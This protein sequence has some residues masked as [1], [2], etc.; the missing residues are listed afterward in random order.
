MTTTATAGNAGVVEKVVEKSPVIDK[1][2]TE[3]AE[4]EKTPTAER[5]AAAPD[6]RRALGRGLES[7]LPSGPRVVTSGASAVAPGLRTGAVTSLSPVNPGGASAA[8][9]G[10][11]IGDLQAQA[12][13]VGDQLLQ[14]PLGGIDENPYQ[15]RRLGIDGETEHRGP[16][17]QGWAG[18]VRAD[19]G[20]QP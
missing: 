14:I 3:K 7:L 9:A 10:T 17:P 19:G 1:T 2:E 12:A 11:V 18:S 5:P 8:A 15:T 13:R 6:K 4:T 16:T 20:N